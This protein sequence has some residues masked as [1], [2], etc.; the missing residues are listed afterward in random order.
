MGV[1]CTSLQGYA[2]A[3]FMLYVCYLNGWGTGKDENAAIEYLKKAK[4]GRI[5]FLPLT[6]IKPRSLSGYENLLSMPGCYGVASDIVKY[7]KEPEIFIANALQPAKNLHVIITDPKK[8]E[9]IVVA[10]SENFSL[11]IGKKG[12]NA[13]LASQQDLAILRQ[14]LEYLIENK[15]VSSRIRLIFFTLIPSGT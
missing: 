8:Q 14:E 7:D 11:A 2:P 15:G 3:M 10:D 5:T 12:Q 1:Q 9:C 13:R 4:Y 6:S